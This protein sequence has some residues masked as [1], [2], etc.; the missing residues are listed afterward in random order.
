MR[1]EDLAELR[2]EL[3]LRRRLVLETATRAAAE[4]DSL[5][6]STISAEP[7][8]EARVRTDEDALE[9]LGDAERRE[10]A[11]IDGA[12]ARMDERLYGSCADCGEEIEARRLSALPIALRCQTCEEARER[13]AVR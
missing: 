2:S 7:E 8:E 9:R 6:E 13:P 5:R 3:N 11:R 4:L 1:A 12:L 10:L